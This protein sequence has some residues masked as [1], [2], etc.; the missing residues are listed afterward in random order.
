MVGKS[1][2]LEDLVLNWALNADDMPAAPANVYVALF[3]GDP[4]DSGEEGTEVTATIRAAGRVVATFGAITPDSAGANAIAN[5]VEVDFGDADG[6]AT[7]SHFA[8]FDDPDPGEG[9]MLYS[10]ALTAG[11]QVIG[12]GTTVRFAVGALDIT[13]A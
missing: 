2:Y 4:T 3:N 13:E 12:A 1:D 5:D 10:A 7:I 9:N 6:Q 8:I 11:S